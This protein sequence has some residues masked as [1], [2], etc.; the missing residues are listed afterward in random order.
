M[1]LNDAELYKG[2]VDFFTIFFSILSLILFNLAIFIPEQRILILS[3][4]TISIIFTIV[5]FYLQKINNNEKSIKII[6][7]NVKEISKEMLER[8]NYLKELYDLKI[9]VEMLKKKN[10]RAQINLIDI[11]KIVVAI[12]LIYVIVEVIKN[13]K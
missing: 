6:H 2:K 1:D 7:N 4:F 10:K 13:L 3:F 5:L 12:I 8:F 9:D 11:I